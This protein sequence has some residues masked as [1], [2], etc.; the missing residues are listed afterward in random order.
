MFLNTVKN[1]IKAV[2]NFSAGP[3]HFPK[4][5]QK[6]LSKWLSC[7]QTSAFDSHL[8]DDNQQLWLDAQKALR[9]F[10][11]IP[12]EFKIILLPLS[13]RGVLH[14]FRENLPQDSQIGLYQTGY[15]SHLASQ[16]LSQD[17][18]VHYHS[19]DLDDKICPNILKNDVLYWVS[20]ETLSGYSFNPTFSDF[21][22]FQRYPMRIVDKTSDFLSSP[23]PWDSLDCIIVGCQK[24][25]SFPGSTLV[26]IRQEHL[27]RCLYQRHPHN[28]RYQDERNST[29]TT[30]SNLHCW[31]IKQVSEL[32]KET[33]WLSL[34]RKRQIWVD[35][36]YHA[37]DSHPELQS[38]VPKHRR[39]SVHLTWKASKKQQ[40]M[41]NAFFIRHQA[42]GYVGHRRFGADFRLSLYP[43]LMTNI[44]VDFLE[45]FKSHLFEPVPS[46]SA[47]V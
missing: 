26:I 12:Q 22:Q 31:L 15:W 36:L 14:S 35:T 40:E 29:A 3:A 43:L 17:F 30:R 32:L 45:K 28:F 33:S 44:P 47:I 7:P 2:L 5:L 1:L 13:V 24:I 20:N 9:D 23:T 38:L 27:E 42:R 18:V 10:D 25:F 8:S 37:I 46:L 6:E 11:N 41:T 34:Q 4:V 19:S 16:A 21:S 39:S